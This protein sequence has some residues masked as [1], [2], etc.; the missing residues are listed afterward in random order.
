M[1]EPKWITELSEEKSTR[2]YS[3]KQEKT[4][5]KK[6][7]GKTTCNSGAKFGQNDVLTSYAEFECKTTAKNSFT[8][9]YEDW[10]KLCKKCSPEKIPAM[11]F[12]LQ[13]QKKNFVLVSLEDFEYLINK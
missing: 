5:A 11:Q 6:L 7:Q 13:S 9:H 3:N 2:Y 10:E 4:L 1:R 8:V 12:E